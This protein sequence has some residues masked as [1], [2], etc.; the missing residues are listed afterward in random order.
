MLDDLY[1]QLDS[2]DKEQRKQAVIALGKTKDPA[3]LPRLADVYRTDPDEEVRALALKA[4]R[5]IRENAPAGSSTT[6][7]SGDPGGDLPPITREVRPAEIERARGYLDQALEFSVRG[8]NARAVEYLGRA[9]DY[10]P[11]LRNDG[12][13]IGLAAD[14]TGLEGS[15]ALR[16]LVDRNRRADLI[17]SMGGKAKRSGDKPKRGDAGEVGWNDVTMDL[18]IYALANGAVIFVFM[19]VGVQAFF[20]AVMLQSTASPQDFPP[21]LMQFF[22]NPSGFGLP[23]AALCGVGYALYAVVVFLINSSVTHLV[24]TSV[25]G[26][27]GT[28][29]GLINRTALF[30]TGFSVA[31]SVLSFIPYGFT[32]DQDTISI[33][34]SISGLVSIGGV[35]Y[36]GKLVGDAYDFGMGK[37]CVSL[38]LGSLIL[39]AVLCACFFALTVGL[40]AMGGGMSGSGF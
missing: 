17:H 34:S 28:I 6:L 36:Y 24:A 4:G 11:H 38:L 18:L 29:P 1:R 12:M 15:A 35:I 23:A 26:G 20:D 32:A 30:L 14:L 37:G 21:E 8:D 22:N 25:M 10:N 31:T 9:F 7:G 19:L 16:L 33:F 5:F 39:G 3:A 2:F 40:G 27:D 13:A